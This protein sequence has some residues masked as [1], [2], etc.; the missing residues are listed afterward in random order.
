MFIIR[1]NLFL[2][3]LDVVCTKHKLNHVTTSYMVTKSGDNNADDR[4]T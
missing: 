4:N 3:K 2:P 1:I